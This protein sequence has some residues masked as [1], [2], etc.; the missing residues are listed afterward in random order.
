MVARPATSSPVRAIANTLDGDGGADT[1][2]GLAGDDLVVGGRGGDTLLGGPDQ[3]E[4]RARDGVRDDVNCGPDDDRAELDL[5]DE[6]EG[7]IVAC[8]VEVAFALDDGP[9]SQVVGRA[10]AVRRDRST[11]LAVAC[12][13]TARVVCGGVLAVRASSGG[14]LLGSARYGVGLGE[15]ELIRVRLAGPVPGG[16]VATTREQGVSDRGPRSSSTVL[17]RSGAGA[18]TGAALGLR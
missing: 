9:P 6:A 5:V 11:R 7:D 1:V 18:F 13:R 4:V 3:D 8:E 12:P 16:V 14:R 2:S 17:R 15:R 10:F